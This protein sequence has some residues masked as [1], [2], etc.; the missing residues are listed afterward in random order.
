LRRSP[1]ADPE[2]TGPVVPE[3]QRAADLTLLLRSDGTD[4]ATRIVL[5]PGRYLLGRGQDADIRV[6]G[7]TVSRQHARIDVESEGASV[8]D[9]NSTNGTRV[10]GVRATESLRLVTGDVLALGQVTLDVVQAPDP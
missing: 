3:H 8:R 7:P 4:T 10:N 5:V 2:S 9:L 6:F 1:A